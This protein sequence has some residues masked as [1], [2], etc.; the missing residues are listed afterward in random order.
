[1]TNG[2]DSQT[3]DDRQPTNR[4]MLALVVDNNDPKQSQRIRV[5]IPNLMEAPGGDTNKLP[6]IG[7]KRPASFGSSSSSGSDRFDSVDIPANGSLVVVE[8]Q[9]GDLN[10]GMYTGATSVDS[11]KIPEHLSKNYPYRR[12]WS[13]PAGNKFFVDRTPNPSEP[14]ST[15]VDIGLDHPSGSFL[16][17]GRSG[18]IDFYSK[19]T[20]TLSA[21]GLVKLS[22]VNSNVEISAGQDVRVTGR[23][24]YLN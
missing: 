8:F 10:F 20:M 11:L 4:E 15:F 21:D 14:P 22:S 24:I 16:R 18:W 3:Q 1:M 6:W 5:T 13:D 19:V 23:K 9:D 2:F 12:G 17:L 7:P